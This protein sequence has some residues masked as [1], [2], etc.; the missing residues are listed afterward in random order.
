MKLLTTTLTVSF[1]LLV[2][3]AVR[4][5]DWV[6]YL[7]K[8]DVAIEIAE[9]NAIDKR[10]DKNHDLIVFKYTNLSDRQLV[11]KFNREQDY[12]NSGTSNS[13]NE[14]VLV[15]EPHQTVSY[16]DD[17]RNKMFYIFKKDNNGWIKDVLTDFRLTDLTIE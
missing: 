3:V 17:S 1:I 14:F 16:F 15:L 8:P 4:A 5:Q 9:W 13:D 11:L 2:S 12:S 6:K 10:I 7:E